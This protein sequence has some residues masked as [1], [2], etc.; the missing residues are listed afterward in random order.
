[1]TRPSTRHLY[2]AVF[3]TMLVFG[4]VKA[5]KKCVLRLDGARVLSKRLFER[6]NY[7]TKYYVGIK[8]DSFSGYRNHYVLWRD[9]E[10]NRKSDAESYRDYLLR[11]IPDFDK[12]MFIRK[13]SP[14]RDNELNFVGLVTTPFMPAKYQPILESFA[15]LLAAGRLIRASYSTSA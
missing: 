4:L 15:A 13:V 10:T 7:K 6:G 3:A 12:K 11:H 8:L 2:S 14:I 5:V 1:M 9:T